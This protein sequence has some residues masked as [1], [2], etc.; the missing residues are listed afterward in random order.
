MWDRTRVVSSSHQVEA[1][2]PPAP[3]MAAM[4]SWKE[5]G[6]EEAGLRS[7]VAR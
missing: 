4:G 7:V 1:G 6:G 2:G 3:R 5:K